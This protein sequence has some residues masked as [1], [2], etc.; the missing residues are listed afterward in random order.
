MIRGAY[1]HEPARLECILLGM[2]GLG[3]PGV[4]QVKVSVVA[5]AHGLPSNNFA[6]PALPERLRTPIR[7][8]VEAWGKQ[9]IPKT[10]LHKAIVNPDITFFGTGAIDAQPKDQ[11][12]KYHYPIPKK[13]GGSEI[14][15]IWT[16][17]PCRTTCWNGG[18][19]TIDALRNPTIECIVAQHPWLEND[20][21]YSDIIL[22]ANTTLEVED[23]VPKI[24]PYL[25]FNSIALQRQAIQPI[26]ESKSDFEIVLEIA[27]KLG[28]ED[29]VTGG[30]SNEDLEKA[31]FVAMGLP[32]L[33]NWKDFIEKEY[34]VYSI[35]KDWEQNPP[36][37]RQFYE[38][39]KAKP[40]PTPTGKLEFYSQSLAKYFP[41]DKERPPIPKWIEK[42]EM[43]D[44]RLSGTRAK[45]YPLLIVSNHGRWRV[46]SQCDDISWTREIKTCKVRGID[47]YL[48]EPLW[49]NPKDAAKRAIQ[50]GDI[51]KVFNERGTVLGGAMVWERIMPGVVYM[52]HG[53]RVDA[54]IPGKLDRGGAI[55]TIAP[56]RITSEKCI[57]E[58]T[59]GYL[60]E[61]E[62]VT[63]K[64]MEEWKQQYPEAFNREYEPASGLRFNAWIE[65]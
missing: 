16:D 1:S 10:L 38:D 37:L 13:D 28:M 15:M 25:Q 35:A 52:D 57:G 24:N 58:A 32:A 11:F 9:F 61:I 31:V 46:H 44:E 53:A 27:K 6:N 30:K 22:P 51:V 43:H 23:I 29:A 7:N 8:T 65:D 2:Q 4:H 50:E 60:V 45:L 49:I 62:K 14:H 3:K 5:R 63:M 56:E 26:G 21:L 47:G 55:N 20:C 48:Y 64:Q 18:N 12:V 36:G 59:S 39:P 17:T 42:S 54:I 40:L 19:E 34:Y 33:T 41:N